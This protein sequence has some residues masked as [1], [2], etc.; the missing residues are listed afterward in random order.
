MLA[1]QGHEVVMLASEGVDRDT[2]DAC[3]EYIGLIGDEH[4]TRWFGQAEWPEAQ[5]W[6][7]FDANAVWW[8]E[9]NAMVIAEIAARIEPGDGIGIIAGWCQEALTHAFPDHP[10][11]EWGVG[12]PGIL[13]LSF[14]AFE[15]NAWRSFCTARAETDDVHWFD[16]VIPNAYGMDEF[17]APRD[18]DGYLLFV[19]RPTERKGLAVVRELALRFP[20]KCAGQSDPQVP[21]A[22]Y[23]GLVR[24]DEKAKLFSGAVALLAPTLY[25]GPFEGVCVEAQLS[26]V[27]AITTDHG[28]F[29]ENVTGIGGWRCSILRDFTNA[30]ETAFG[31][32]VTMRRDIARRARARWSLGAVAPQYGAWLDRIALLQGEG[33]YG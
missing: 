23:V 33:W 25:H 26:G 1:A 30:C 29:V 11:I 13:S 32:D 5:V 9:W 20:V 14:R 18:H 31:Y 12:Y 6:D 27:P 10:H 4:R 28:A 24:G 7:G 3:S 21:G 19:G 15:S 2:H 16:A 22:E 17:I 8:Q